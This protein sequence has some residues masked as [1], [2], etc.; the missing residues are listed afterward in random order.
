MSSA[1]ACPFCNVTLNVSRV[2]MTEAFRCPN[3]RQRLKFTKTRSSS[4]SDAVEASGRSRKD[5]N[6]A[7]SAIGK[8][9]QPKTMPPAPDDNTLLSLDD[10]PGPNA[11][12]PAEPRRS[13]LERLSRIEGRKRW[14]LVGGAGLLLLAVGAGILLATKAD[15]PAAPLNKVPESET[16]PQARQAVDLLP[17]SGMETAPALVRPPGKEEAK[18]RLPLADL[19]PPGLEAAATPLP[20]AL[21]AYFA[22]LTALGSARW[23]DAIAA[24]SK[25][26]EADPD[27][28]AYHRA[29]GVARVLAEQFAGALA[30]LRRSG[31]LKLGDKES[32]IWLAVALQMSGDAYHAR[33]EYPESTNDAYE[34]F[35]GKMRRDYSI[36]DFSMNSAKRSNGFLSPQEKRQGDTARQTA[37]DNFARAGAWYVARVK[38]APEMGRALLTRVKLLLARQQF[39]DALADLEA[40]RLSFPKDMAVLF[41][42]ATCLVELD[43]AATARQEFTEVL[44]VNTRFARAY[45]GRAVA[46]AKLSDARRARVDLAS[47]AAIRP[48]LAEP[49][50]QLVEQRLAKSRNLA[51]GGTPQELFAALLTAAADANGKPDDLIR[52]ATAVHQAVAARRLNE[53]E[54]YQGRLKALEDAQHAD[55]RNTNKLVDLAEFIAREAKARLERHLPRGQFRLRSQEVPRDPEGEFGRAEQLADQAL[56]ID[57]RHARGLVVKARVRFEFQQFGDA[58]RL[59][60]EAVKIQEDVPDGLEL[61]ARAITIGA[62]QAEGAARNLSS[63]QFWTTYGYNTITYWTRHPSPE[64]LRNAAAYR[65][66]A[67]QRLAEAKRIFE[68]AVQ[69]RP[70]DA[71]GYEDLAT[72]WISQNDPAKAKE[73]LERALQ[74]DPK[75]L[76]AHQMLARVYHDLG[77]TEQAYQEESLALSM[78]EGAVGT[79][80]AQAWKAIERTAY[81]TAEAALDRAGQQDPAEAR[82]LAY[83]AAIRLAQQKPAEAMT[84]FRAATALEEARIALSGP[85]AVQGRPMLRSAEDFAL[86]LALRLRLANQMFEEKRWAD[87]LNLVERNIA[88]GRRI[89]VTDRLQDLTVA[90][91]PE[92]QERADQGRPEADNAAA[93]L[94]W[95][96]LRAGQ[97]LWALGRAD[98]AFTQLQAAFAMGQDITVGKGKRAINEPHN[99]SGL[100]LA[101]MLM[102][103]GD[104]QAAE[105][106]LRHTDVRVRDSASKELSDKKNQLQMLIAK[107]RFGR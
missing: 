103:R 105:E 106:V 60:R 54:V 12:I 65:E 72:Y 58:D 41:L 70:T 83:R 71:A 25:A 90:I 100:A 13:M 40:L 97:A 107:K 78:M 35:L 3:C 80:L 8:R 91:L 45:L 6:G 7:L 49:A 24:F 34:T 30:D 76:S 11:E 96:H 89:A 36:I 1:V 86:A 74:L 77:K 47:A 81:R 56:T 88:V 48:D 37:R 14:A 64:D 4:T 61:L 63:P 66:L 46:N 73:A 39:V 99:R 43:D 75:R 10:E 21:D 98:E 9:A 92:S 15:K 18:A 33:E 5:D 85:D 62:S 51:P 50:R 44:T 93:L 2:E 38:T 95:S 87:A 42:H 32:R 57:P 19:E 79:F 82:T 29:R 84:L 68:R 27:H 104:W 94:A 102:G 67:R 55:P 31:K 101:E 26:I 16:D 53:D 52:K 22:G 59:L 20:P 28:E 17:K 23:A 69:L